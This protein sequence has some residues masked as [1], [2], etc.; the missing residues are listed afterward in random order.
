[1][2]KFPNKIPRFVTDRHDQDT[3]HKIQNNEWEVRQG[4][5]LSV[6]GTNIVLIYGTS[7]EGPLLQHYADLH[8]GNLLVGITDIEYNNSLIDY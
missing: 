2:N 4:R 6:K 1:M 8:N 7:N 5:I 3:A